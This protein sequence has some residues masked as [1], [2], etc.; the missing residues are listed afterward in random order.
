MKLNHIIQRLESDYPPSLAEDWDNPGLQTGHWEQDI[1]KIY[2]ALD[3]SDEV[4]E[5]CVDWKADLLLTHHPLLISGIKQ[6]NDRDLHGRKILKMAEN[7]LSHFAMHTNYDVA[8]M[9]RLCS[10]YLKMTDLE[11]LEITGTD[12][13]LA[14]GDKK[15]AIPVGIGTAGTLPECM[16][17]RECCEYVKQA[18]SLNS[19]QVFG[20]LDSKVSR[21]A[22]CPGSGKSLI[23]LAL[24]KKADVYITGDVGHHDGLDAAEQG[25]AVIDAGHYG[26]EH[27]F[28]PQMEQY[29][30]TVFPE[31]E[32]GT[33]PIRAPFEVL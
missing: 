15:Q 16:T 12:T 24:A 5:H 25:M 7:H 4:L 21:A 18:F 19:V 20:S 17:L 33:E 13:G 6:I 3:A 23:P 27:V 28:I 29:L 9:G 14:D 31:L 8:K 2:V 10:D 32:I 26:L 30:K 1:H 22:L 11:I